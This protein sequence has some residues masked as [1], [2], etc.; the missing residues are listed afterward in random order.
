M[1]QHD[2][3]ITDASGA[4]VLADLNNVL[5][6]IATGNRGASEPATMFENMFWFDTSTDLLKIRNEANSAWITVAKKDSSGWTPYRQGTALGTAAVQAD[7]RYAHRSSDLSDL[8][9]ASTARTNLGLGT[10]ATVDVIDEDD[11]A[12]DSATR[13]PSQ[14][15]VAAYVDAAAGT[16]VD[17]GALSG[18]S[19]TAAHGLG[20]TPR[21]ATWY[22]ECTTADGNFAVGDRVFEAAWQTGADANHAFTVWAN[23]TVVGF[24]LAGT[25]HVPNK[26]TFLL[27]L[28]GTRWSVHAV[29]KS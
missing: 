16:T 19:N 10:A 3:N 4:D 26:N 11:F 15:S 17:L 7:T 21:D 5:S 24:A 28:T 1:A 25:L 20:A 14:Q 18:G 12:T 13:P 27:A 23:S 6:A 22:L 8:A 9:S 29:V 2:Y